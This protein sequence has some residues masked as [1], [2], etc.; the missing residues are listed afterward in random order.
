MPDNDDFDPIRSIVP[1]RDND[2]QFAASRG[3]RAASG[4]SGGR[5]GANRGVPPDRRA[6][7]AGGAGIWARLFITLSL[8]IAAVACGWAWQL[9]EEL[10]LAGNKTDRYETRIAALEDLL[11]DTDETV[12][13]SSA[14]MSAQIKIIDTEVRKLWD[15]RK[16]SNAS[17]A[18]LE[19][20]GKGHDAKLVGMARVDKDSLAQLKALNTDMVKLKSVAGDL[21]RLMISARANQEDVERVADTLNRMSADNAKLSTR[22][23]ANEEWVGSINA[24]RRQISTTITQLQSSVRALQAVN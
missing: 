17:I 23:A 21:E 19:K 9:Q 15:A 1:K 5:S 2:G 14:A 24:F 11:S 6:F 3:D 16:I 20:S 8:V 12:N 7:N 4:R 13:R 18:K 10:R 22:V